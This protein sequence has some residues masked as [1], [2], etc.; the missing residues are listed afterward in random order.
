MTWEEVVILIGDRNECGDRLLEFATAHNMYVYNTRFEQK[1]N[2]KWTWTSSDDIHR[3][4]KNVS[5]Q[6]YRSHPPLQHLPYP[7]GES[8]RDQESYK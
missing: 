7:L 8:S 5:Q 2:W 1:S 3:K 4:L 6:N